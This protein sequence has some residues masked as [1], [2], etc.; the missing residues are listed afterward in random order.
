MKNSITK[1]QDDC[2]IDRLNQR[3]IF[4]ILKMCD[5]IYVN[6]IITDYSLRKKSNRFSCS[7]TC[8]S[9]KCVFASKKI[10]YENVQNEP[11]SNVA[12]V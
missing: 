4:D 7:N 3:V 12:N 1:C 9:V 2:A 8:S 11:Q 10:D 5:F 6:F